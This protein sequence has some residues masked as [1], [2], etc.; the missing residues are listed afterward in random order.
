MVSPGTSGFGL[1]LI[2]GL[3]A[4]LGKE[5]V[6]QFNWEG[7]RA[8]LSSDCTKAEVV[9]QNIQPGRRLPATSGDLRPHDGER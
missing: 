1:R 9:N 4:E 3:A 5:P 6:L 8:V 7:L 2:A